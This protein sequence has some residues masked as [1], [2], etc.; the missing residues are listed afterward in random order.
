MVFEFLLEVVEAVCDCAQVGW[1]LISHRSVLAGCGCW[2]QFGVRVGL[3]VLGVKSCFVVA[4]RV[5]DVCV[6]VFREVLQ[7][8]LPRTHIRFSRS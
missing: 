4:C 2:V 5:I 1:Q 6:F 7:G 3:F 8:W